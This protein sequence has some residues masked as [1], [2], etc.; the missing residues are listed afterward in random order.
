MDI[1]TAQLEA[2]LT[3]TQVAELHDVP[4]RVVRKAA[5]AGEIPGQLEVLGK[6]GFDPDLVTS[7]TPPEPGT[8]VVGVKREDGRQRYRIYL[9]EEEAARL[10]AEGYEVTDPRV[11]SKARRAAR[12][13]AKAQTGAETDQ[14]TTADDDI[15]ADF[16]A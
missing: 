8:R 16:G 4:A 3:V 12:A 7:W 9:T 5:K 15:F 1:S 13:L 14:S 10:L 11:A 6:F 2:L